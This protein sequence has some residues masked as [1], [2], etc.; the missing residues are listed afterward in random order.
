MKSTIQKITMALGQLK[1]P[2]I[3][4]RVINEL[5]ADKSVRE[6][7]L[8]GSRANKMATPTSDLDFLVRSNSDPEERSARCDSIDILWAGP[9]GTVLLLISADCSNASE[10]VS[11]L[12]D[13]PAT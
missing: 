9:S 10:A 2:A 3:V 12:C 1:L 4:L 6:I 5:K 8:I 11:Q 7:W 13:L